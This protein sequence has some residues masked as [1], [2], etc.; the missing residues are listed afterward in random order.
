MSELKPVEASDWSTVRPGDV[1]AIFD[2]YEAMLLALHRRKEDCKFS[3]LEL[4]ERTGLTHG[5]TSKIFGPS[6]V[7]NLGPLSFGRVLGALGLK[8]ALVADAAPVP[9]TPKRER[10]CAQQGEAMP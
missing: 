4:D 1:L 10:R 3:F 9:L 5:H 2:D 8:L 6:H 7:K